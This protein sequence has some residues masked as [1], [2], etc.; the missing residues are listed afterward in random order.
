MKLKFYLI[1]LV[2][3]LCYH[4][5]G[6]CQQT[7]FSMFLNGSTEINAICE[8][9]AGNFVVTGYVFSGSQ[10]NATIM[11][12]SP[13]GAILQQN[14]FGSNASELP[15]SIVP[16]SAGYYLVTGSIYDN[17]NDYD[18]FVAK[19]DSALQLVWFKRMGAVSG[20][21][22]ANSC[23]EV[24]PDHF[25]VTGTVG[26]SGSAKPSTIMIDSAGT[27]LH[28]GY[29]NT[30]QFAS[31]NYRGR[32]LGNGEVAFANLATAIA[33]MDTTGTLIKQASF[34]VATYTRDIQQTTN[35]GYAICGVA[36]YGSPQG[37]SIAFAITD[38]LLNTTTLLK[39]FNQNGIDLSVVSMDIDLSGNYVLAVNAMGLSSGNTSP[40][41]IRIDSAG[42]LISSKS[43][44]PLGIQNVMLKNMIQSSDGSCLI[45][46]GT[47]TSGFIAKVDSA[48]SCFY[49]P[50]SL[51]N[52]TLSSL[53][54]T[55][56]APV[57]G[58]IGI[59]N[60]QVNSIATGTI[61]PNYLCNPNSIVETEPKNEVLIYPTLTS[62]LLHVSILDPVNTFYFLE[63]YNNTGQLILEKRI[64][65]PTTLDLTSLDHGLYFCRFKEMSEGQIVN[66]RFIKVD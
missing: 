63:I 19:L 40:V 47:G 41:V 64:E 33:V 36:G 66:A 16:A 14:T 60:P 9:A 10:A 18:W 62:D 49:S 37:S 28:E 2:A 52:N 45:V 59:I 22:Y 30:N 51:S 54:A 13:N 20:N 26:L 38:S 48:N 8:N 3:I 1:C 61:S 11:E 57:T 21:D 35:G 5:Q 17:F 56:H 50:L 24:S 42:N 34:N 29:L 44:L 4:L 15:F 12:L 31:P 43:Y 58:A 32:Y 25:V 23:Y 7:A 27:V 46:G 55:P 53:T 65:L 39:R 6:Q